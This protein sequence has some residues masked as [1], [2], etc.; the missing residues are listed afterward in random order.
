MSHQSPGPRPLMELLTQ[1]LARRA[2]LGTAAC[3][4]EAEVLPFEAV[5]APLVEPRLAWDDATLAAKL[6]RT[7]SPKAKMPAEWPTLATA[8]EPV[9]AL[10]LCLGN[11]PQLVRDLHGLIQAERLSSLRPVPSRSANVSALEDQ[12]GDAAA[13][14]E[15]GRYLLTLGLL[16]IARQFEIARSLWDEHGGKLSAEWR[17]AAANE[18][19]ALAWH[20]GDAE[21]ARQ[22]WAKQEASVP[23]LFNRG[24]AALFSDRPAEAK[25]PLV[26]AVEQLPEENGWH[27]LG[28]LYLALAASRA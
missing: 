14:K 13:R 6:Y 20:A 19:A 16:R 7:D 27:H 12:A 2:D 23:V 21:T 28:R 8:H 24:M 15:F 10:P 11:F 18:R 17:P 9:L 4:L 3:A 25:T 1:Y 26:Q 22:Q 5:S